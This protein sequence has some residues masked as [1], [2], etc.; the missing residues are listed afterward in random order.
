MF[1]IAEL[2]KIKNMAEQ[3]LESSR[4]GDWVSDHSCED[5]SRYDLDKDEVLLLQSILKKIG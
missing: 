3:E 4:M 2:H 5:P 1:N